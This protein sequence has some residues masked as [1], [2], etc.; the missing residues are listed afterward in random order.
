VSHTQGLQ[1]TAEVKRPGAE[2]LDT[3]R[4]PSAD[5]TR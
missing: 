3:R 4:C 1:A 2:I 5:V